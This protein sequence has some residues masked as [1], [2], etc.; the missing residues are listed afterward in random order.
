MMFFHCRGAPWV[1]RVPKRTEY[2]SLLY[3]L[4][5]FLFLTKITILDPFYEM[6]D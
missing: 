5:E 1:G 3:F 4:D 6:W 2:E